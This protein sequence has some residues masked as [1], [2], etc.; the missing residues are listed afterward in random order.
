MSFTIEIRAVYHGWRVAKI[1]PGDEVEYRISDGESKIKKY[2]SVSFF[3]RLYDCLSN[4][5]DSQDYPQSIGADVKYNSDIS[6]SIS[7]IEV[8][9]DR[10]EVNSE[11]SSALSTIFRHLDENSE[12]GERIS[13]LEEW[14]DVGT[15]FITK[16][17]EIYEE[18][19]DFS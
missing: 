18:V 11:I 4:E 14:D 10:N 8:A 2:S 17:S 3:M 19:Q 7:G 12:E 1:G 16:P 9:G 5:L 6:I 15:S 13:V